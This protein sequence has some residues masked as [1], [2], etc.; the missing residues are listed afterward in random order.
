MLLSSFN[1]LR[2]EGLKRAGVVDVEFTE[3]ER[4]D[5]EVEMLED[6]EVEHAWSLLLQPD[7]DPPHHSKAK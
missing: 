1:S 7:S 5:S 6:A 4:S 2:Q 3:S